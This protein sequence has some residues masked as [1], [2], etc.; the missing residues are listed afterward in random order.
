MMSESVAKLS[1][2][3]ATVER[4]TTLSPFRRPLT[5]TGTMRCAV[6]RTGFSVAVSAP[7]TAAPLLMEV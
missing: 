2:A 6:A 5:F 4:T 7:M 1:D 3:S